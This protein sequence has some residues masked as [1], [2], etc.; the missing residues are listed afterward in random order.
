MI[1]AW[2]ARVAEI[3][4]VAPWAPL[5]AVAA[6]LVAEEAAERNVI[7]TRSNAVLPA[8]TGVPAEDEAELICGDDEPIGI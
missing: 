5:A 2:A 6:R 1:D 7:P 4:E 8:S 3:P